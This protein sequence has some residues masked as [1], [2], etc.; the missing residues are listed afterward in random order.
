MPVSTESA[1]ALLSFRYPSFKILKH[2][3]IKPNSSQNNK[4]VVCEVFKNIFLKVDFNVNS[5]SSV[6]QFSCISI[7]MMAVYVHTSILHFAARR[8]KLKKIK[9]THYLNKM[10]G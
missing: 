1:A 10:Y 9:M 3:E 6:S 5:K 7:L 8:D 4:S 2:T